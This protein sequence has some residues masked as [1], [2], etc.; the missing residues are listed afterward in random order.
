MAATL[1]TLK[2]IELSRTTARGCAGSRVLRL[3]ARHPEACFRDCK[4]PPTTKNLVDILR[5]RAENEPERRAFT[6]LADGEKEEGVWTY[7]DLDCRARAIAAQ[8]QAE[9]LT[10]ERA[11]LLYPSGLEFIAAFF[12]CLYAGVIAVPCSPPRPNKPT[13]RLDSVVANCEPAVALT[14]GELLATAESQLGKSLSRPVKCWN[15][16]SIL[17]PVKPWQ[18]NEISPDSIAFLQYTSGSTSQPKGAMLTHQNI[19]ANS[20]QIRDRF[21]FKSQSVMVGWLPNFHDMGLVG[22]VLQPV[23]TGFSS[24]IMAP[25][26][27]L[28]KP[29][30]LLQAIGRYHATHY[31]NPNFALDHCV[32]LVTAED[33]S[34]L[35][36]SSLKVLWN[37]AEPIRQESLVSFSEAFGPCGFSPKAHLPCYGMAEATLLITCTNPD[38][39]AGTVVDDQSRTLVGCGTASHGMRVM[40]VDPQTR[41]RCAD[42]AVGEIWVSGPSIAKG[43]WNNPGATVET[44][45]AYLSDSGEGPFMCTGDLGFDRDG[46]LY[47]CGRLKDVIIIRGRNYYPQDIELSV[48]KSHQ[49]VQ[50]NSIAAFS[51]ESSGQEHVV[52]VAELS[53]TGRRANTDEVIR[54]IRTAAASEH[55]LEVASVALLKPGAIL[56]TTSGKI[57]RHGCRKA[58]LSAELDVVAEWRSPTVD[59]H[60][61][62]LPSIGIDDFCR[63]LANYIQHVSENPIG[64]VCCQTTIASLGLD[65]AAVAELILEI[66][67]SFS[68]CITVEMFLSAKTIGDLRGLV[69]RN[70]RRQQDNPEPNPTVASETPI[71]LH[72]PQDEHPAAISS[73]DI[74]RRHWKTLTARFEEAREANAYFYQPEIE[75]TAGPQVKI[76]GAEM[77]NLSSYSYLG[78]AHHPEIKE[79]TIAAIREYG[80]GTHGSRLLCG[81]LTLH[82]ELERTIAKYKG[83]EDAIVFSSG[84]VA[85]LATIATAVGMGDTVIGDEL[86]H[87]SVVDGCRFSG[88]RFEQFAH[89]NMNSLEEKLRGV[90]GGHTMV[91]VDAVYSMEGD[92]ANLPEIV[93]LCRKFGALLM[94]DEAHSLGVLGETG[95][96]IEEHFGLDSGSIDIKMGTLSKTIPSNG[97]YVAGNKDMI[98]ALRHSARGYIFSGSLSVPQVA[99]AIAAFRVLERSESRRS[100]LRENANRLRTGLRTLGFDVLGDET[101]IVPVLCRD[102]AS[103][104][105]MTRLC[106]QYG[107]LVFP[108]VYPAVPMNSP[109]LRLCVTASLSSHHLD[110]ALRILE[111]AGR[112]A[113]L[114]GQRPLL[115]KVA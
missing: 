35:D 78:L 66:E 22:M 11:V 15:T 53:R 71:Q 115:A 111:K 50:P 99:A 73:P 74:H 113:G 7:A 107:L 61:L 103:A 95:H 84:Y 83:A 27:F 32:R 64:E 69:A 14:T 72:E 68:A 48:E 57:Q 106:R 39:E 4:A 30:R 108:V 45:E 67:K 49:A 12:G 112:S 110:E 46:Q 37:G 13:S 6:F 102:E 86:N 58:W 81:T 9:G 18:P 56:K 19:M 59:S 91:V 89:N 80:T 98:E 79:A 70:C 52:V 77:T 51:V 17:E 94:V 97:G 31:G 26:S 16:E 1:S 60:A 23:F 76:D 43:Y 10:G 87:A 24:I 104:Y 20:A 75:S 40:I 33:R 62:T 105:E 25:T 96:G 93:A 34:S 28:Q 21:E 65:S 2:S 55:G 90:R 82:R 109:R 29:L 92:I 63:F 101:P 114:I 36:L 44:F 42:G 5:W 47:I 8:L 41:T 3:M 38:E 54:A 85:N 88:A 100:R